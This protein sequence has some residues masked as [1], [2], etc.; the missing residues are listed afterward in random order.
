MLYFYNAYVVRRPLGPGGVW[1][2]YLGTQV[3]NALP[4][5]VLSVR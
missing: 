3:A 1:E 2:D 4:L 5:S